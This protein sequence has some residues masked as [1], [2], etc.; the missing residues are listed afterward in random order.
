MRKVI[1]T[2]VMLLAVAAALT[3]VP[4]VDAASGGG[5][6][7][8]CTYKCD[9]AGNPLKCCPTLSGGTKCLPTD[10]IGCPQVY[11]C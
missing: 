8:G 9:C 10:E 2:V 7:S 6:S 1:C 11:N 3:M 5:S 4:V